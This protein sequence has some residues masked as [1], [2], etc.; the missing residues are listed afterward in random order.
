MINRKIF[1]P[2]GTLTSTPKC[3]ISSTLR[4]ITI[5]GIPFGIQTLKLAGS[6]LWPFGKNVVAHERSNGCL[7]IIFNVIRILIGGKY[8]SA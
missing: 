2:F 6:A 4:V 5:V 8:G 3:M 1:Y 7:Y